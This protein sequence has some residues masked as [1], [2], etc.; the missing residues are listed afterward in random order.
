M[1]NSYYSLQHRKQ[2]A[3]GVKSVNCKDCHHQKLK[4]KKEEAESTLQTLNHLIKGFEPELDTQSDS[5]DEESETAGD[6]D[7]DILLVHN[8]LGPTGVIEHHTCFAHTLH[9]VVKDGLAKVGQIGTVIRK[10]I[11]LVSFVRK[12]TV[13]A[14]VLQ[15]ENRLQANNATRQLKMIRP[16]SFVNVKSKN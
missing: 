3:I 10:C 13:A 7:D 8:T 1:Q 12:S 16:V 15:H 2:L 4:E 6:E 5:D 14:D 9:L 11:N